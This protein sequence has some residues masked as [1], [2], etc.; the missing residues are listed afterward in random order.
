[1]KAEYDQLDHRGLSQMTTEEIGVY[2]QLKKKITELTEEIVSLE[3]LS[4]VTEYYLKTGPLLFNYYDG[5]ETP[6]QK[7]G[8]EE[9][10]SQS[11]SPKSNLNPNS[12]SELIHKTQC[13]VPKRSQPIEL[14]I[15]PPTTTKITT[16]T[17]L[18]KPPTSMTS[19]Q[20]ADLYEQYLSCKD[21]HYVGSPQYDKQDE[22]CQTVASIVNSMVRKPALCLSQVR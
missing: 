4:D 6:H 22:F 1:M 11:P 8:S 16:T 18:P 14:M 13:L 15:Q 12:K 20:R 2:H 21:P 5:D 19:N 3:S 17:N 7:G 10:L 9:I